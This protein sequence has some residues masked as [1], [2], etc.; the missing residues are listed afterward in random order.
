MG[1]IFLEDFDIILTL[2]KSNTMGEVPN[3]KKSGRR[4]KHST[5]EVSIEAVLR[6]FSFLPSLQAK[7]LLW[8]QNCDLSVRPL[9]CENST[10]ECGRL[11]SL[12]WEKSVTKGSGNI[13][14]V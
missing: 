2:L 4:P 13:P 10:L 8:L 7:V 14:V 12:R 6:L 1:G 5:S 9:P 11:V 3:L